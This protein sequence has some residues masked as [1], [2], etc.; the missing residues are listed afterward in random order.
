MNFYSKNKYLLDGMSKMF[1]ISLTKD[2]RI[3][4]AVSYAQNR[5]VTIVLVELTYSPIIHS[6]IFFYNR[7]LSLYD[8]ILYDRRKIIRKGPAGLIKYIH[9][10]NKQIL[11]NIPR[12]NRI[13]SYKLRENEEGSREEEFQEI[14]I[15]KLKNQLRLSK[16]TISSL[17]RELKNEKR[18]HRLEKNSKKDSA[19]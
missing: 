8:V 15:D 14:E 6:L 10:I 9:K 2:M 18:K 16:D 13:Y 17:R 12:I 5:R 1:N 3:N 7:G 4:Y 19:D 11:K